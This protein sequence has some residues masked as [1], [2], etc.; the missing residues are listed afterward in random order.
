MIKWYHLQ[1]NSKWNIG[2][3]TKLFAVFFKEKKTTG[4]PQRTSPYKEKYQRCST[5]RLHLVF[6]FTLMI[7][8]KASIPM[9]SYFQMT[10]LVFLLYKTLSQISANNLNKDLEVMRAKPLSRIRIRIL[11]AM[12]LE[13][14]T[15]NVLQT[16]L[17]AKVVNAFLILMTKKTDAHATENV[18]NIPFF[19]TRHNYF[20]NSFF[21]STII[22]LKF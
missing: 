13:Q 6:S 1:S 15:T 2:E 4:S 21:P 5:S 17:N 3:P 16:L 19:N 20:K 10:L 8:Q 12:T 14:N 18:D 7:L 22:G 9:Q 11:L